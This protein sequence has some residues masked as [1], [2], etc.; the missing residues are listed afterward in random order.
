LARKS[1]RDEVDVDVARRGIYA[2]LYEQISNENVALVADRRLAGSFRKVV[3][4]AGTT[5][6]YGHRFSALFPFEL[7]A[8]CRISDHATAFG[9]THP[10]LAPFAQLSI[11][12]LAS[13]SFNRD[14]ELRIHAIEKASGLL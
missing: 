9:E 7:L 3:E 2:L 4:N 10:L 6:F 12:D 5:D 13:D 1:I 11:C 8:L 14:C